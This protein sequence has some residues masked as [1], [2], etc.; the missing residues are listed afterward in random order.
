[1]PGHIV[2]AGKLSDED[3]APYCFMSN[4]PEWVKQVKP[5]DIIVAGRNFGCGSSRN[6]AKMLQLNGVAVVLAE[7]TSRIFM[8]NSVNVGMPT[9]CVPAS[10]R[11][12][13]RAIRRRSISSPGK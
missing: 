5:G 1:M 8:R 9:L 3:A 10:P 6:G 7:S 13:T 12:S 2:L 11:P 4:R